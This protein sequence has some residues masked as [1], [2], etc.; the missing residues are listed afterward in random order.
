MSQVLEFE[1]MSENASES[2]RLTGELAG[3]ISASAS[4]AK[5]AR[6]KR[7]PAA[8][9]LG[10]ILAVTL[11]SQTAATAVA[12]GIGTWIAKRRSVKLTV[13]KDGS[14]IAENITSGEAI[15]LAELWLTYQDKRAQ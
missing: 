7:D 4:D 2:D 8:M 11:G 14:L 13:R 6:F 12:H 15:K 1:V 5:V 9:E 3:M 10:T